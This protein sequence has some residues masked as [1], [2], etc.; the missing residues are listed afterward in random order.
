MTLPSLYLT[1]DE[2]LQTMIERVQTAGSALTDFTAGSVTRTFFE[3][4]AGGL[5]RGS[6]VADQLRTDSYL[7]TATGD[8]LTLKAADYQVARK[9]AVAATGVVRIT[10]ADTTTAVTIPAGWGQ[11]ATRPAPGQPAIAYLTSEAANFAIGVGSVDVSGICAIAGAAGNIAQAAGA[12]TNVIAVNPVGGFSIDSDFNLHGPWSRGVDAET[13]D[14]LRARVPLEV[15]ARV[16]GR[17]A[18]FLAA[19]LRIPGV[20]SAQVLKAGDARADTTIVPAGAVEVY[21][22]GDASLLSQVTSECQDATQ[23][24]QNLA[25]A[26]ASAATIVVH[27]SVYCL[28]GTDT[29]LLASNVATAVKA[30]VNGVGVGQTVR[31]SAAIRAVHGVDAVV[32]AAIPF[33]DFRIST[34]GSGTAHDLVMAP[35]TYPSLLDANLTVAVITL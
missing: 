10:R 33:A 32:S 8:A 30:A 15:A 20:Q 21:Y 16:K 22:E 14:A 23:L 28:A 12:N 35:Q 29:A 2:Y 18:S 1:V 31:Y 13:D 3:G 5:S 11:L 25:V 4:L 9:A 7:Q 17:A 26:Q 27:L 6:E 34:E 24:G 19:A